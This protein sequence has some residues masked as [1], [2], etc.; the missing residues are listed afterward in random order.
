MVFYNEAAGSLLGK[1][2][3]EAG[4]MTAEQW[5]AVFG[6]FDDDGKPIPLEE[7]PITRALRAGRPVHGKVQVQSATGDR[8]WIELSALPIVGTESFRG[9]MA[10][11]WPMEDNGT[12]E[13]S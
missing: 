2:F 3:E 12:G 9:A 8:H 11:F 10:I 6:P 7:L 5:G 1:A 13:G 4:T